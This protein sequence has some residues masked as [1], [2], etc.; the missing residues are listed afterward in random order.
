MMPAFMQHL[1]CRFSPSHAELGC[2]PQ[3]PEIDA[4]LNDTFA[5]EFIQPHQR[6]PVTDRRAHP[7]ALTLVNSAI[8]IH[9]KALYNSRHAEDASAWHPLVRQLLTASY[10]GWLLPSLH[11]PDELRRDDD[12][13]LQAVDASTKTISTALPPAADVTLDI[14]LVFDA[15]RDERVRVALGAGVQLNVFDDTNLAGKL[16]VLGCKVKPASGPQMDVEYELG[17]YGMKTLH[18]MRGI[19]KTRVTDVAVGVDVCGHVWSFHVTYWRSDG[20]LV[21][22]GPVLLGSTDTLVGTLK[23]ARWMCIFQTWSEEAW[24]GWMA[25]LEEVTV[26]DLK[27]EVVESDDGRW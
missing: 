1:L 12:D 13:Y 4:L 11:D 14:V 15:R 5:H 22:H 24:A 25:L 6:R 16:V 17:V 18:L 20:A 23:I 3:T 10:D 7:D 9:R 26:A 27:L 2:V 21:T 8:L 19:G